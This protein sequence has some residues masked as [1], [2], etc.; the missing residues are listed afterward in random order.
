MMNLPHDR[1]AEA[2]LLGS[3]MIDPRAVEHLEPSAMF[4]EKHRAIAEVMRALHD[5]RSAIDTRTI[6]SELRERGDLDTVGGIAFLVGFPLQT[7][8]AD[9]AEHYAAI[10]RRMAQR[11]AIIESASLAIAGAQ[12]LDV[13]PTEVIAKHEAA[14]LGLREQ[15]QGRGLQRMGDAVGSA[16]LRLESLSEH[17]K[18][19]TGVPTGLVQLDAMTAGLQPTDVIVIAG[20]P[21]AGKT[22][23]AMGIVQHAAIVERR[24]SAVFSL[25][26]SAEQLALRMLSS[27]GYI[28]GARLRIG[29]IHDEDWPKLAR[30][31][32]AISEAPIYVDDTGGITVGQIRAELRRLVAREGRVDLIVVDYLQLMGSPNPKLSP[33]QAVSENSRALKAIAKEFGCPVIELSQLSRALE[34]RQDKRPILSDLRMSGAIEQDA[35]V[36]LFVYRDVVYNPDT[37]HPRVAE[38]IIAKQRNGPLG[39]AKV[40]FRSEYTRFENLGPDDMAASGDSGDTGGG[41]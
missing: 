25:E 15:R 24:I 17:K 16:F 41:W 35:D 6:A 40:A 33:E 13:D 30:A 7:P 38:L 34:Q 27:E 31:A 9:N 10:V 11:R 1:E 21:S 3:V 12:S 2:A 8:T 19:V 14:L 28:E 29:Q 26:M 20:R 37:E 23:V 18:A 39:T 32:S 4:D 5:R 36:V 22:S